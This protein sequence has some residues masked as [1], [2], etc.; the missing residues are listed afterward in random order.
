VVAYL[1]DTWHG[2][3]SG[4]APN[5]TFSSPLLSGSYELAFYAT[6]IQTNIT[7]WVKD[8]GAQTAQSGAV[9]FTGGTSMGVLYIDGIE[10][11][12]ALV[13]GTPY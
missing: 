13:S 10:G 1:A 3:F 11:C 8:Y 7:A 6:N 5:L 2:P 4:Y 12:L 9:S